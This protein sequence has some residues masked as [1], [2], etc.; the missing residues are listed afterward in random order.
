[1]DYKEAKENL[2]N[3]ECCSRQ[4]ITWDT[5]VATAPGMRALVV[6]CR[7]CSFEDG[8]MYDPSED[9][10]YHDDEISLEPNDRFYCNVDDLS[11]HVVGYF[12]YD[13][14]KD[15]EIII[16]CVHETDVALK[17]DMIVDF[18][19]SRDDGYYNTYAR[20]LEVF[21]DLVDDGKIVEEK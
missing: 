14:V 2:E 4:Q 7:S 19:V 17:D 11:D 10:S 6:R 5:E 3:P 8:L 15:D 21:K 13:I 9:P 12:K 1:M 16:V 18:V 20:E